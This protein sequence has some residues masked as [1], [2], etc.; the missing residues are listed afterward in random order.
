MHGKFNSGTLA[1]MVSKSIDYFK[2][3]QPYYGKAILKI[4][5]AKV[6]NELK[7]YW[8]KIEVLYFCIRDF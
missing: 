1:D 8:A 3:M 6:Q 5:Y 2:Q 7:P 4:A